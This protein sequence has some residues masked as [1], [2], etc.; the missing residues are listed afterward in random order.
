MLGRVE[1]SVQIRRL[2]AEVFAFWRDFRNLPRFLGDVMAVRPM[3]PS[4]SCWTIQGPLSL[5]TF[6]LVRMTEAQPDTLIRYETVG[7]PGLRASWEIRFSPGLQPDGA[8]V[9]EVMTLPLGALGHAALALIG[10][11]PRAEV[12][13]NLRRLKQLLETG[14]VTDTSHAVAGKFSGD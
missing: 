14:E 10:K 12:I 5:H 8:E 7:P 11:P 9:R 4:L 2:P 1:A 13:A 6:S 3:G